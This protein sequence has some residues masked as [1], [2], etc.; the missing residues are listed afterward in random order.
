MDF[1]NP[2]TQPEESTPTNKKGGKAADKKEDKLTDE[3]SG[4]VDGALEEWAEIMHNE[5]EITDF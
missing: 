5:I 1:I 3:V 4:Y 2:P